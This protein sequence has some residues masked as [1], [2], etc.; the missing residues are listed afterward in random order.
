ML[1]R[2]VCYCGTDGEERGEL[3]CSAGQ[4]V[5]TALGNAN[6]LCKPWETLCEL[7]VF[8]SETEAAAS[9]YAET[10]SDFEGDL[11]FLMNL[12]STGQILHP[13]CFL[14][15]DKKLISF[16]KPTVVCK[17]SSSSHPLIPLR[18]M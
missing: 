9:L 4:V 16:I 8:A 13:S 15:Q 17:Q 18:A 7:I 6:G 14:S 1:L 12:N 10:I 11:K 3:Q 2:A 5:H